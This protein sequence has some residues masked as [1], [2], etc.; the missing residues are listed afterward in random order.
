MVDRNL[1]QQPPL[2]TNPRGRASARRFLSDAAP[3]AAL[4]FPASC[5]P[6]SGGER[7]G[8]SCRDRRRIKIGGITFFPLSCRAPARFAFGAHFPRPADPETRL[9]TP[10]PPGKMPYPG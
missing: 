3:F 9:A 4:F 5:P 1:L 10:L 8:G 2:E 7:R 6:G